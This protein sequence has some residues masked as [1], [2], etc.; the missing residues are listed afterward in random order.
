M[1]F[2]KNAVLELT[3]K[4]NHRCLFCSCPWE[5]QS[6]S[7]NRGE[8][9]SVSE[10]KGAVAELL[11]LGVTD[12]SISGGEAIL[13]DGAKE[14]ISF[15]RESLSANKI[16]SEITIISNGLSLSE[17][18]LKFFK[19]ENVRLSISLPGLQTFFIH[20]G[21]NNVD[22]VLNW[23][24]CAKAMGLKTTA[25]ITVTKLNLFEL[26]ETIASALLSGA[27][28][29]LLNRF[30]PGGRGLAYLKD[31]ML[32]TEELNKM[33]EDAEFVL[34]LA[35]RYGNIGTEIPLCSINDPYKYK[36]LRIGYK[37]A[38]ATRFFVIGPSG[39]VR[40]CNH[41]PRIVGHIFHPEVI[42]DL[43]YW[44]KYAQDEL[45][46]KECIGCM[47]NSI[48]SCGCREVASIL[49]KHVEKPDPSLILTHRNLYM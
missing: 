17:D 5:D 31:L 44:N 16:N 18:W 30:L 40:T 34:S 37:C 23:F 24:S 20:T 8:E 3:Y 22:N 43:D 10:W 28:D 9:L 42:T 15:I 26:K 41:S 19:K 12:F 27:Y 36:R 45:T 21:M 48:C 46:I 49:S 6:S 2:P 33:L 29:V 35:N 47:G 39:E 11:N 32:T 13:R 7:Y 14:I 38:A 1:K 25:N 4:C